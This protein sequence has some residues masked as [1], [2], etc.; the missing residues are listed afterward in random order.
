[1]RRL[2][3]NNSA[4]LSS[5]KFTSPNPILYILPSPFCLYYIPYPFWQDYPTLH[6]I[7]I[8]IL[9]YVSSLLSWRE[10]F[11]V[12]PYLQGKL[13]LIAPPYLTPERHRMNYVYYNCYPHRVKLSAQI[14]QIQQDQVAL[15]HLSRYFLLPATVYPVGFH[16]TI[17]QAKYRVAHLPAICIRATD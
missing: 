9:R 14:L 17:G 10:A 12:L 5:I 13:C 15:F 1:M 2:S 7:P 3:N 16:D 11:V 4:S 8:T 6:L